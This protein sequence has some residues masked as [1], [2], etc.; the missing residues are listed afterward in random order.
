MEIM[1]DKQYEFILD[2]E[3]PDKPNIIVEA[4]EGFIKIV[5]NGY[6][7]YNTLANIQTILVGLNDKTAE[8]I[9]SNRMSNIPVEF[10]LISPVKSPQ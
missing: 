6:K 3:N 2:R 9:S 5:I 8:L 7:L 10:F 1:K 4:D